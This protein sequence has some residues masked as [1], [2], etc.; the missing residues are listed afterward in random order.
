M[1]LKSN[2]EVPDIKKYKNQIV[3]IFIIILALI[4]S[5]SIYK[6]QDKEIRLLNAQK[7]LEISKNEVTQQI[8]SLEKRN[9]GYKSLLAKRDPDSIIRA[10]SNIANELGIKIVSIRPEGQVKYKLFTKWPF[11]ISFVTP[12]YHDLGSFVSRLESTGEVFIIEN[13][14]ATRNYKESKLS[15][16]LTFSFVTLED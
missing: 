2:L 11:V 10:V 16:N 9:N 15:V 4:I 8:N 1:D 6:N 3:N 13:I 12:S 7:E 14:T 5:Q